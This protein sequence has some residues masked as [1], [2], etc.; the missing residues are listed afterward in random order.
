MIPSVCCS[1]ETSVILPRS[2]LPPFTS[3]CFSPFL[4]LPLLPPNVFRLI[5]SHSSLPYS[6][7]SL[8]S[9]NSTAVL[10]LLFII[11]QPSSPPSLPSFLSPLL[12]CFPLPFAF[13]PAPS[14]R[15]YSPSLC[16][17]LRFTSLPLPP[18]LIPPSATYSVCSLSFP[19][20]RRGPH[21]DLIQC[22]MPADK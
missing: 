2:S 6:R 22:F 1:N 10:A 15:L 13:P 4:H 7:L 21:E 17:Y 8:I 18:R 11:D 5:S 20:R 12:P 3:C 19:S 14:S 16:L 9:L